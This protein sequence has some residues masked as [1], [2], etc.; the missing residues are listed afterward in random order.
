MIR[1]HSKAPVFLM[2]LAIL[3]ASCT[4]IDTTGVGSGLI[5]GVDNIG[6]FDTTLNII[7][8][9]VDDVNACDSGISRNDLQTVG[10]I[11]DNVQFGSS[12]AEMYFGLKPRA[13]PF[14][15]PVAE[16]VSVEVDSVVLVLKYTHSYGDTSV[17][18]KVNVYELGRPLQ[19][20]SL[21]STCDRQLLAVDAELLGSQEFI[22][23]RLKDSIHA[24]NE[25]DAG[26]LR[27]TLKKELG[28]YFLANKDKLINDSAFNTYF[29]GFAIIPDE[30]V[31]GQ[32]LN[33]FDLT[34]PA[35]RLSIYAR[36]TVD[37]IVDTM[38][39]N[40]T[41][42]EYSGRA[43][44][45]VRDRKSSEITQQLSLPGVGDSL[46]FIQTTPGS[47]V[48]LS[49]PGLKTL[50]NMVVHRAEIIVEQIY[51]PLVTQ[52]R[53]PKQLLLETRLPQ[54]T[55]RFVA[56][57]CDFTTNELV[58]GFSNYGGV[59]KQVISGGQQVARYTFNV[60]RYVQGI[61][62]RGNKVYDMRLSAPYYFRNEKEYLDECKNAIGLFY[63][64]MNSLGD[65]S[66]KLAGST[67]GANR[68]RMHIVYSKL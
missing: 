30:T 11:E 15:I 34:S 65:G 18:Q 43:N 68:I 17:P 29:S 16:G 46:L 58:A 21:Y 24:L 32:A 35:T 6:T 55:T 39:I 47:Y 41:F 3:Y 44:Y 67:Q 23:A 19:P 53:V 49:I 10:I 5:P 57:P 48:T 33:Y 45:I 8:N 13:Y 20:D 38:A 2:L 27:I 62:T 63:Y 28:E 61:V 31:G 50:P 37:T 59:A 42:N 60:S 64:P 14:T 26:Q 12:K 40:M 66:V 51:D 22:P 7:A 52:F 56:V 1:F 36:A 4:K 54:D 9:T 25:D